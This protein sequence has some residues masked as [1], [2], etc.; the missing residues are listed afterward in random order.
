MN[1]QKSVNGDRNMVKPEY[2]EESGRNIYKYFKNDAYPQPSSEGSGDKVSR[3]NRKEKKFEIKVE[4]EPYEA[5]INVY[6][7]IDKNGVASAAR[8]EKDFAID[9][10][11]NKNRY[12]LYEK[13]TKKAGQTIPDTM[14]KEGESFP[15]SKSSKKKA[16]EFVKPEKAK[17]SKQNPSALLKSLDDV[18]KL[19]KSDLNNSEKNFNTF[20]GGH[21]KNVASSFEP[22]SQQ[23]VDILTSNIKDDNMKELTK[24]KFIFTRGV[25]DY[26]LNTEYIFSNGMFKKLKDDVIDKIR[27]E[28][29]IG[30]EAMRKRVSGKKRTTKRVTTKQKQYAPKKRIQKSSIKTTGFNFGNVK[31]EIK[32]PLT[33]MNIKNP[34]STNSVKVST[35]KFAGIKIGK[36]KFPRMKI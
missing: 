3:R 21:V 20:V 12:Q 23:E 4:E 28:Q 26:D 2:D 27:N 33:K 29:A 22:L 9:K 11:A 16:K 32:K 31:A 15:K 14:I 25:D 24:Q 8:Q 19:S 6:S 10:S 5:I 36:I 35:P 34:M 30:E 18:G 7:L 1:K 13:G 17:S